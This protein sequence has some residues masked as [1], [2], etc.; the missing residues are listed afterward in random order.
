M[1]NIPAPTAVPAMIMAPPSTEGREIFWILSADIL[2][3]G[4]AV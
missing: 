2:A 1:E 4:V 3:P